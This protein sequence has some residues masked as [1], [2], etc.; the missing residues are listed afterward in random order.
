MIC[1]D[2]GYWFCCRK[3]LYIVSFFLGVG[4]LHRDELEIELGAFLLPSIGIIQ[5]NVYT[6]TTTQ[7][8]ILLI[9]EAHLTFSLIAP[10]PR[11]A[12]AHEGT[13][14]PSDRTLWHQNEYGLDAST[15]DR[16]L[17]MTRQ[18]VG[19]ELHLG[20]G[21]PKGLAHGYVVALWVPQLSAIV[22]AHRTEHLGG[23]RSTHIQRPM[24]TAQG[25]IN[26]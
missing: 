15:R 23:G 7:S 19:I 14:T 21:P 25:E 26:G 8:N 13:W 12:P 6:N 9:C 4:Y 5:T 2:V 1:I 3:Y 24:P 22:R 18:L 16:S 11:P 20:H 17:D 10:F